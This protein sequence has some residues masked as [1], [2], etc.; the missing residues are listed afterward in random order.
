MLHGLFFKG[1][2]DVNCNALFVSFGCTFYRDK[3]IFSESRTLSEKTTP[4]QEH[5]VIRLSRSFFSETRKNK[6]GI[7]IKYFDLQSLP[8]SLRCENIKLLSQHD[9]NI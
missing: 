9:Q 2:Q 7:Y 3:V 5:F 6:I 1:P 8:L 4:L